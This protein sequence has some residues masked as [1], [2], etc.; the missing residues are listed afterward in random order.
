MEDAGRVDPKIYVADLAAYNMGTL[1]GCWVDLS[2]DTTVDEV[3]SAIAAMLEESPALPDVVAEE[4]AIHDHEGFH[5]YHLEE[6]EHL[7]TVVKVA[8]FIA[9]HG[10]LGAKLVNVS[11]DVDEAQEALTS[12]YA[13]CGTSLSDWVEEHLTDTGQLESIPEQWRRY[14]DFGAYANDLELGGD[15]FT[16]AVGADIHVFWTT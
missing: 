3:Q 2:I 9:E 10:E 7:E 4:Y 14:I 12:R 6:H 15:I 11:Y 13:G 5:G 8:A 1:H 16:V